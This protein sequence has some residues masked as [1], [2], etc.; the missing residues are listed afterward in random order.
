VDQ[1]HAAWK[2]VHHG[3]RSLALVDDDGSFLGIVPPQ[4]LLSVLLAE[5]D[6]DI[7]HLGGFMHDAEAARISTSEPI[8]RRLLHRLPWLLLGLIGSVLAADLV[9][10]FE[11]RL[12]DHLLLVFFIPGIVYLADAVGTQTEALIIRGIAVG[13][14]VRSVVY[15]EIITG[16]LV[17]AG[18]GS[19]LFPLVW[20]RWGDAQVA[21]AVSLAVFVACSAANA[22]ALALPLL[23]RALRTDPAFGSGPLATVTQDLLSILIYLV[24]ATWLV[25]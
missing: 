23:M 3:E 2:A 11:G 20:W 16:V 9:G 14:P 22:I 15:R 10:A 21:I 17:G 12:E 8:S 5:H 24:I 4:R 6:A 1:E 19:A 18:L 7:A 13:V 25:G